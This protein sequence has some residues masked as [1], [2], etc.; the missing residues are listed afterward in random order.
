VYGI[1][2]TYNA[3]TDCGCYSIYFACD[4]KKADKSMQIVMQTLDQMKHKLLSD[5][6]LLSYKE[7]LKAQIAMSEENNMAIMLMLAKSILDYGRVESINQTFD[8][9]D[10]INSEKILNLSKSLF[11]TDNIST[12]IYQQ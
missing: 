7:Q 3:F 11:D 5:R 12:L 2:S 10:Q 6:Q 9:I 1:D 4:K 8:L